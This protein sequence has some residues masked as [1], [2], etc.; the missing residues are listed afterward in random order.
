MAADLASFMRDKPFYEID[1]IWTSPY[2]RAR[3]T[4]A[5]LEAAFPDAH[6]HIVDE[7]TPESDPEWARSQLLAEKQSILVVGHNPHLSLLARSLMCSG[8]TAA[9]LSFKKAG[10]MGFKRDGMSPTGFMLAAWLPP[11]ALGLRD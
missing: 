3:E 6:V 7:L 1:A 2:R 4:A 11:G 8:S 9:P 5:P 10:L